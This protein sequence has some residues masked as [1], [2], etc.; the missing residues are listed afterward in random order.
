MLTGLFARLRKAVEA[1]GNPWLYHTHRH[2]LIR[3]AIKLHESRKDQ[4]TATEWSDYAAQPEIRRAKTATCAN[5]EKVNEI[6]T[7]IGYKPHD[8]TI[9]VPKRGSRP[10]T[11]KVVRK[12]HVDVYFAFH[13]SGYKLN[14]RSYNVAQVP[15]PSSLA[16]S[17][18]RPP[19]PP[20]LPTLYNVAQVS[21]PI[22]PHSCRHHS[23]RL[24]CCL[25]EDI[26]SFLKTGKVKHGEWFLERERLPGG[27]HSKLLP[28]DFSERAP[29]P[30]DF[31][32]YV[33]KL[34]VTDGCAGQFDGK[35]NYH[36]T[37]EW[38]T[39][40]GILRVH[41]TLETMH[42]KSICDALG[43]LPANAIT[44]VIQPR[45]QSR[46][47]PHKPPPWH[48]AS[49]AARSAST[50]APLPL[51]LWCP[52]PLPSQAIRRDEFIFAGPRELVIYLARNRPVPAV[53]K[54]VKDGWWAVERIF[55]GFFEH[56]KFTALVVPTAIGFDGSH[57]MHMFAGDCRDAAVARKEGR[58]TVRGTPC[59][60][61]PCTALRWEG[62]EM[63]EAFGKT[64]KVKAPR[65]DNETSN[66]QQ[67]KSLETWAASLKAKQL[68]AVRA[69]RREQACP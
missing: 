62:C 7:V 39:K 8:L 66:L 15:T 45:I 41:W 17:L 68:V 5:A 24:R 32:E 16:C 59:A 37:A 30:P 49:A 11:T 65:A 4:V 47:L 6:V 50:H 3:H 63:M 13:A 31:P 44:E 18:V 52:L 67:I 10:A 55:Y 43:N 27:D 46:T 19:T 56:A 33:R 29:Q 12:Q 36:Q 54:T 23:P 40:F 42:G 57:D 35:D 20:S 53:A 60:C 61:G 48:A 26:D 2:K 25:Q 69:D 22:R 64:K 9:E 58:L 34:S 28:A 51:P 1:G 38:H 14:A 21:D